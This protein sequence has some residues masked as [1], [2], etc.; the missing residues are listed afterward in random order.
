MMHDMQI[1]LT[2]SASNMNRCR[3]ANP[4]QMPSPLAHGITDLEYIYFRI[5]RGKGNNRS[6][7]RAQDIKFRYWSFNLVGDS[8]RAVDN[9]TTRLKIATVIDNNVSKCLF[10]YR[11][12]RTTYS[13]PMYC[14]AAHVPAIKAPGL[15][16]IRHVQIIVQMETHL[17]P[18]RLGLA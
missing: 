14:I 18:E 8:S 5:T 6:R 4:V 17:D 12:E 2:H 10:A 15:Q 11:M 1:Y 7:G 9:R 16:I 13:D 3:T